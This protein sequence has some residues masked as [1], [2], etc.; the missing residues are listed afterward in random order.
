MTS[1]RIKVLE[2]SIREVL[3]TDLRSRRFVY[4]RN[5][6]T[7]RK[8]AGDCTQIINFQAGLRSLEGRF[9]VNLAVY[10]P[11]YSLDSIVGKKSPKPRDYDCVVRVRLSMLRDTVFTRLFSRL[12][13]RPNSIITWLATPTDSW[14]SFDDGEM[15]VR[16]ELNTVLKL[17]NNKGFSWLERNSDI[18]V[19]K[20]AHGKLRP[21]PH[22]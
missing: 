1:E 22:A 16:S 19:L 6:R 11:L 20:E 18:A 4:D 10:H 7:F 21:V 17:L 12:I 5:S 15:V 8:E 2:R 13:Q 3:E 9:A 14:W